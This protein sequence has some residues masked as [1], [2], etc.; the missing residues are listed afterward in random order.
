MLPDMDLTR[1]AP[2]D[3]RRVAYYLEHNL[4]N[5]VSPLAACLDAPIADEQLIEAARHAKRRVVALVNDVRELA[6]LRP[7][8]ERS[9]FPDASAEARRLQLSLKL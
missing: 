3:R 7:A 5:A 9:L 4:I 1:L 6:G 8:P 2:E